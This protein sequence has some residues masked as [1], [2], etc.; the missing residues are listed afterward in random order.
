MPW[1]YA[2][3]RAVRP[4]DVVRLELPF[5]EVCMHMRVAGH[6]MSAQM[7]RGQYPMMQLLNPSGS[8]F[9]APILTSEAGVYGDVERGFYYYPVKD[10]AP[11]AG[12]RPT[13]GVDLG[14]ELAEPDGDP[15]DDEALG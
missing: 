5:S 11:S 8:D 12:S 9:S 6:E 15:F 3:P 2:N 1:D 10:D 13:C 7:T 14:A 4:G